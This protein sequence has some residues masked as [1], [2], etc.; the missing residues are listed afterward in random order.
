MLLQ[1]SMLIG[2]LK[3]IE[4]LIIYLHLM[5]SYLIMNQKEEEKHL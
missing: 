2:L 4:K 3:I 1:N 5:E